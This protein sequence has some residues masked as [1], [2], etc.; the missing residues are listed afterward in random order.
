MS[1][2][3]QSAT[4]T[5]AWLGL[6]GKGNAMGGEVASKVASAIR[7]LASSSQPSTRIPIPV[8]DVVE[9]FELNSAADRLC[10]H[11]L[12]IIR[13]IESAAFWK[14]VWIIQEILL[15]K[16]VVLHCGPHIIEWAHFERCFDLWVPL[17]RKLTT[18][19]FIYSAL[20]K[21]EN[22][23]DKP[24]DAAQGPSPERVSMRDYGVQQ[25]G[26][27]VQRKRRFL[28]GDSNDL[29]WKEALQLS[30]ESLCSQIHDE[31]FGLLGIVHTSLQITISRQQT[32]SKY[33]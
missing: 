29:T 16:H 28:S 3:Y 26:Y 22:V 18:S 20:L 15:S 10:R 24:Q 5:I 19:N 13:L 4:S 8:E 33:C 14:R 9:R 2:I 31:M 32:S 1:K 11:P 17:D 30:R 6:P 12:G 23:V 25:L 7:E 21:S 27:L